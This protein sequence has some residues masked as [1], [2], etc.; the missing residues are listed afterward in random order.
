METIWV[1]GDQL[2]RSLGALG[3]ATP[4]T[5]RLLFVESAAKISSKRFHRQ[6]LH[7]V[8]TAMRRFAG[9]CREEGFEVDYRAAPHLAAGLEAHRRDF[10]PSRVM[11]TEPL[12]R[13][14]WTLLDRLG[15]EFHRS[16]QFL[17]HHEDF[18]EWARGRRVLR[19]EDFYRWQRRRLGYLMEGDEPAGGQWNFD[20]SNREPP[21]KGPPPWPPPPV[22]DLDDLDAEV[23]AL[24]PETAWGDAPTGLWATTRTGA[25]RRLRHFVDEVLP[26]F[27]PHEDAMTTRSWHL[28]H[29][30]LSPYLNIGLL[31]PGEVCDAVEGAYRRGTVSIE[32]A[33]GFIRQ[34]IGWREFVWGIYWLRP[35]MAGSNVLGGTRPLPPAFEGEVGTAMRCVADTLDGVRRR[36]WVH[37]IQRLMVLANLATLAGVRPQALLEWMWSRFVDGAEWVMVPNVIGMGMWADGGGMSSKPYVSGGAY[38]ARMS[39]YCGDCAFDPTRRTGERA[40]PFTTLYWDFLARHRSRLEGNHRMALVLGGLGRLRDLDATRARASEILG[41]LDSGDL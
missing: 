32:S 12:S 18:A 16:D 3:T 31:L 27:G 41:A 40:C 23:L 29:S 6:R 20:R 11:A 8:L 15:V 38:I 26:G 22:D 34:V 9:E 17:C 5:A 14:S 25:L 36:G 28:A 21:P 33:E 1:L 13:S 7:L 30:L 4:S 39:D 10:G 2:N 37:H 19:M 35:E 24:L